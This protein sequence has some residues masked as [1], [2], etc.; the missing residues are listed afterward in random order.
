[1]Q[2]GP[3]PTADAS[4]SQSVAFDAGASLAMDPGTGPAPAAQTRAT[5]ADVVA[6]TEARELQ[7]RDEIMREQK[8]KAE[9]A[10]HKAK[11]KKG[12]V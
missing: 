12:F 10:Q 9:A 3:L 2:R 1:M 5:V 6:D 11:K 4:V 7:R 8:R